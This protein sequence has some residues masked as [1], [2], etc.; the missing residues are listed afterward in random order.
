MAKT[1]DE[2]ANETSPLDDVCIDDSALD[3]ERAA[4][5]LRE[6]AKVGTDSGSLQ[7]TDRFDELTSEQKVLVALVAQQAR[8]LR[9]DIDTAATGPKE[10]ARLSSMKEGTVRP[11]VR[12]LA[13]EGFIEDSEDGYHVSAAKL[14][15]IAEE[16]DVDE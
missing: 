6:Y 15:T 14:P 9:G 5:I 1:G 10:T 13:E 8:L 7:P 12:D 2:G 11:T 16:L 3:E 4:R